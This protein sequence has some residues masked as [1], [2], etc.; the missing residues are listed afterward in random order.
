MAIAAA[1]LVGGVYRSGGRT[2]LAEQR[3]VIGKLLAAGLVILG[4]IAIATTAGGAP[5]VPVVST[6]VIVAT[7]A[8]LALVI[9]RGPSN[10]RSRIWIAGAAVVALGLLAADLFWLGSLTR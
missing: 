8:V 5:M 3:G 10:R 7:L 9:V 4:V 6:E 1:I 2:A